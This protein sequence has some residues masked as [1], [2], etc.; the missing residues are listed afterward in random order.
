MFHKKFGPD[1]FSRFDVYWIQTNKQTDKPNL[2]IDVYGHINYEYIY[3]LTHINYVST[4]ILC[5]SVCPF[6][7]KNKRQNSWTNRANIFCGTSHDPQGR[8]M[9]GQNKKQHLKI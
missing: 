2:Y 5:L 1:R 7:S 3:T 8:F 6:E 9:A 4:Y